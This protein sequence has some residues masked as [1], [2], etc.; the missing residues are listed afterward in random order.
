MD[1]NAII[2]RAIAIITKPK[3]EWEVIKNETMT[4]ADMYLKYAVILAAIP[5]IA[6]FIG[7]VAIGKSIGFG[8]FRIPPGRALIWAILTYVLSLAGVY[9]F[10]LIIDALAPSFGSKKDMNRSM[11]VTVF[12]YTAAWLGGIFYLIPALT[13]IGALVGIYTL[14]LLY[15][16]MKSLKE[17]PQDKMVG[18]YVVSLIVALVVFFLIGFIA[19][20]IAFGAAASL[21]FY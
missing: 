21:M 9:I 12:S 11:K 18:Y 5:A 17:V 4:I 13:I 20:R 1:F 10:A 7:W 6:G 15:M 8:T 3:D 16:G 14:V 2:K 19:S